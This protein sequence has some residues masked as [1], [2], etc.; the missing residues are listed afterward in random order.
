MSDELRDE[1]KAWLLASA[2]TFDFWDNP[3]DA[4]W[5]KEVGDPVAQTIGDIHADLARVAPGE[6][7]VMALICTDYERLLEMGDYGGRE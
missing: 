1:N 3:L 4:E 6:S 2:S 5:D 7:S